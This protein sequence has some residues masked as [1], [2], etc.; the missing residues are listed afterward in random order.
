MAKSVLTL[1]IGLD[2]EPATIAE[3]FISRRKTWGTFVPGLMEL[4]GQL[5]AV[6]GAKITA[7][8][9]SA[10]GGTS[11]NPADGTQTATLTIDSHA[12]LG[13]SDTV[14]IGEQVLTWDT[15]M[16]IGADAGEDA[17]NLATAINAAEGPWT[18][19]SDGTD[20]VTVTCYGSPMTLANIGLAVS[21]TTAMTASASTF[22]LD[23]TDSQQVDPITIKSGLA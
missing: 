21:D 22:A 5:A 15:D 6:R 18:A 7:Q 16:S 23:T 17:D 10:S 11:D 2:E 12:A 4:V 3:K 9:D 14:T 19:V 8:I 1:V 13:S 20:T